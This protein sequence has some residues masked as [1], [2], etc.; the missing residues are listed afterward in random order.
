MRKSKAKP[1]PK[2]AKKPAAKMVPAAKG[3][4]GG[5]MWRL[6]KR[7]E[8]ERAEQVEAQKNGHGSMH[9]AIPAHQNSGGPQSPRFNVPRRKAV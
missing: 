5:F 7:K 9:K 4:R 6:L 8:A 3:E 2:K 1:V